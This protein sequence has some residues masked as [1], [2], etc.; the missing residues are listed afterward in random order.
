MEIPVMSL[1]RPFALLL[2]AEFLACFASSAIW[3]QEPDPGHILQGMLGTRFMIFREKVQ[4]ELKLSGEQREELD[5][6]RNATMQELQQTM[7]KAQSLEPPERDKAV[8]EFRQKA[9]QSLEQFLKEALKDAQRKRLR[10]LMLQQEGLF[11]LGQAEVAK[12]LGITD[13]QR[14]QFMTAVQ[15]LQQKIEPLIKQAQAGGNPEDIRPKVMKARQ[16]QEVKIETALTDAQRKQWKE[17]LG[18][19]FTLDD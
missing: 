1:N 7:E 16:E 15:G 13:D 4:D 5:P 14:Q 10:Q 8:G 17:M 18:K 6:R 3:A 12:E 2:A 19:P 11:S 9:D